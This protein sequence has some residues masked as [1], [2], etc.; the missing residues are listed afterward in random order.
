MKWLVPILV[1]LMAV[2]VAASRRSVLQPGTPA[3]ELTAD[4]WLNADGAVSLADLREK[5]VVVEF[6]ATWCLPCW[7]SIPHLNKLHDRWKGEGVV[8]I[9]LTDEP[10]EHVRK[11]VDELKIRYVVGTDSLSGFDYAVDSIPQAFVIDGSGQVVWSGFPGGEL[12][13]AVAQ[14]H[15]M[16]SR[17]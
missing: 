4:Q 1:V 9:A 15:K 12:D 6:W 10:A 13:Q 14:A 11:F 17:S 16:L 2:Y 5:V 7:Q 8:V 3:P